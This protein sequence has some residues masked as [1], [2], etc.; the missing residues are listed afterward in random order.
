MNRKVKVFSL[1]LIGIGLTITAGLIYR[2]FRVDMDQAYRRVASGGK[3]IQTACGPIEYSEWGQGAPVLVVHGTG[4]GYDQGEFLARELGGEF[5]WIAPSRFGYLRTPVPENAS[6]I[7]QADAHACLLDALG[8]QRA[9]VVAYSA[10]GPSSLQFALRYPQR[11]TSLVMLSAVSHMVPA[12]P[13]FMDQVY[14]NFVNDFFYWSFVHASK[15]ALLAALG[16]PAADQHELP[17]DQIAQAYTV[18][19]DMVPMGARRG[20]LIF[21]MTRLTTYDAA[22]IQ[23]IQTPTLVVHGRTDT[24]VPFEQGEFTAKMIPGAQLLPLEKGGHFAIL[25]YPE[26][27]ETV[28]KF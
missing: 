6:S 20:G 5:R 23:H 10:G 8:I 2:G 12:R 25:F 9:A 24:L 13:S 11:I 19:D 16:V 3:V 17:Q 18:L 1:G 15:P 21:D 27:R 28:G 22:Q 14:H 4:G 7:M 26:A